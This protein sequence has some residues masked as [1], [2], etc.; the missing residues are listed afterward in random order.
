MGST[1]PDAEKKRAKASLSEHPIRDALLKPKTWKTGL[2]ILRIILKI[3]HVVDK[4]RELF[5]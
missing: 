4:F 1:Q 2:S 3:F 5:E